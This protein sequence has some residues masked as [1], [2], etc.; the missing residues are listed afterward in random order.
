[1]KTEKTISK[2]E[3]ILKLFAI[4]KNGGHI[5]KFVQ[6]I[7]EFH[8]TATEGNYSQETNSAH[9]KMIILYT[10]HQF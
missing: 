9:Y 10:D 7:F 6:R 2:E 8:N 5:V 3:L 1:M 4:L